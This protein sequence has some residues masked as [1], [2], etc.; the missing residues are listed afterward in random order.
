[1]VKLLKK[2]LLANIIGAT[3]D[4]S[5]PLIITIILT[6]YM[7]QETFGI[8]T[9]YFQIVIIISSVIVSPLTLFFSREFYLK[10]NEKLQIY[11]GSI[12]SVIF[13]LTFFLIKF[14]LNDLINGS[15]LI[16]LVLIIFL[17]IIYS[18]YGT[19]LRYIKKDIKYASYAFFR[20]ALFGVTIFIFIIYNKE[21]SFAL[22][23]HAFV[24]AH[25]PFIFKIKKHFKFHWKVDKKTINEFLRLMFYGT[26]ASLLSGIDKL[27]V[28]KAGYTYEDLSFYA[29]A[30]AFAGLPSFL[31]E[32]VKQYMSPK[33]FHDLSKYGYYSKQTIFL[34]VKFILALIVLQFILPVYSYRVFDFLNLVNQNFIREDEFFILLN[35]LNIGFS[36]HIVYHFL[37]PYMFF[38]DRSI[39]LLFLQLISITSYSILIF[40]TDSL[41]DLKLAYYRSIMFFVVIIGASFPLINKSL[42]RKHDYKKL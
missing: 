37:N 32:A 5:L 41:S 42:K 2:R 26:C 7:S 9:Q 22:L 30:L 18:L 28:T 14:L 3:L 23:V 29:Y 12:I 19:Y 33:L 36:F 35:I 15:Y 21:L 24:V 17:F 16:E 8:W 31:I 27:I 20:A 34:L 39:Y 25:L 40:S 38:Y 11:N 10:S 4:K 1:M 13:I 6:N